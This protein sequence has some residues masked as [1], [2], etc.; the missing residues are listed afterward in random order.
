METAAE[1]IKERRDKEF[2]MEVSSRK[3]QSQ[4]FY[5]VLP[6]EF[7]SREAL[8]KPLLRISISSGAKAQYLFGCICGTAEAMP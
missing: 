3:S 2:F 6:I 4:V 1:A 8:I 7:R 5:R